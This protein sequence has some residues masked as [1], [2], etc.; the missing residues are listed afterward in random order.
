MRLTET[1]HV[2][3]KQA[4]FLKYLKQLLLDINLTGIKRHYHSDLNRLDRPDKVNFKV[5]QTSDLFTSI[6]D[7]DGF[8]IAWLK[9]SELA[10]WVDVFSFLDVQEIESISI[11][12]IS[13]LTTPFIPTGNE[14]L[15]HT[16]NYY[17]VFAKL[18]YMEIK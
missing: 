2:F 7:K 8:E 15:I 18:T 14:M 1:N 17:E 9:T 4:D 5:H 13:G 12:Y 16:G 6:L 11:G 10:C 3:N